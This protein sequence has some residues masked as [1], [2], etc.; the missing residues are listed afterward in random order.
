[1]V[2]KSA[3]LLV[4]LSGPVAAARASDEARYG[5]ELFTDHGTTLAAHVT[6]VSDTDAYDATVPDTNLLGPR[7]RRR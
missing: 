6:L 5:L 1:M 4:A 3:A 7:A 2:R